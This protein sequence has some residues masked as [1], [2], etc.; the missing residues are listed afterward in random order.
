MPRNTASYDHE[1]LGTENTSASLSPEF[2]G[3]SVASK[4]R[5]PADIARDAAALCWRIRNSEPDATKWRPLIDAADPELREC[6][7]EYLRQAYR[8][9]QQR[10]RRETVGKRCEAGD[11]AMAALKQRY[12]DSCA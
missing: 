7:R 10:Q 3:N 8:E 2:H 11:A 12:G 4:P 6:L 9:M 5:R 1:G